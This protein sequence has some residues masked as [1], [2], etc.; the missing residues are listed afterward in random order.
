M[1]CMVGV[2]AGEITSVASQ[3]VGRI[4]GCQT[5]GDALSADQDGWELEEQGGDA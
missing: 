3:S 1:R 5:R 4:G 2:H